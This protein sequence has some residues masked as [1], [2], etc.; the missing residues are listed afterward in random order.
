MNSKFTFK[1]HDDLRGQHALFSPSSSAW[2][3]YEE[4]KVVEKVRNQYRA[5]LGT[6]IHEFAAN[7]IELN[8]KIGSPKSLSNEIENYI[9]TKYKFL[10]DNQEPSS[11]ALKLIENV[12]YLPKEVFE[13]VKFY[14]NDAIGYR[15]IVEQPLM[16]SEHIFG[17]ADS[18]IFKN[19][20]LRVHDL[21]T[22]SMPAHMEQLETYAALFCLEYEKRPSEIE[23]ELR[24]YQLDGVIVHKPT[25]ETILPIMDKI[26]TTEKLA[27]RVEMEAE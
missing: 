4:D 19:N 10:S 14:V 22:G 16:Y 9:Y 5:P 7:Q 25:V 13:T 23:I 3:R 24:L 2:L 8:H 21:K 20:M 6:E 18:I 11:Y 1:R 27:A 17:T 12:G 26:I 15:M